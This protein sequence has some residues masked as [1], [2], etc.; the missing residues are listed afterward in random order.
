MICR[1]IQ[2]HDLEKSKIQAKLKIE[3]MKAEIML[4]NQRMEELE[5]YKV[6]A[7]TQTKN[8]QS[9][10]ESDT[11]YRKFK[12]R[13]INKIFNA[14]SNKEELRSLLALN[15][16]T[17]FEKYEEIMKSENSVKIKHE[18]IET[19]N[20]VKNKLKLQMQNPAV[21][22]LKEENETNHYSNA[23]AVLESGMESSFNI[24]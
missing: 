10:E 11:K 23:Q 24:L 19:L 1:N 3:N 7:T 5:K 14:K 17:L 12:D 8:L 16:E 2:F 20:D 13:L 15:I 6:E 9:L 21:R 22:N 4:K 18:T